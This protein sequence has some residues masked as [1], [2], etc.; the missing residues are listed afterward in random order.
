METTV[1]KKYN[2]YMDGEIL[3]RNLSRE[4]AEHLVD[5]CLDTDDEDEEEHYYSIKPVVDK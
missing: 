1:N 4:D 3:E 5:A 2:V